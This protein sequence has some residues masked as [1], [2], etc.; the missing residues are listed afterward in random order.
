MHEINIGPG[1]NKLFCIIMVS[2][3]D[4]APKQQQGCSI[5]NFDLFLCA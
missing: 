5:R 4:G 1:Q 2:F 3:F